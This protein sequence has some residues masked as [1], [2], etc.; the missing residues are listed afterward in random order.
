MIL[1]E[2]TP[3]FFSSTPHCSEGGE[4][5]AA[6]LTFAARCH[7]HCACC[8]YKEAAA[9]R[10]VRDHSAFFLA[11]LVHANDW[12][13]G[14]LLPVALH[15]AALPVCRLSASFKV[16]KLVSNSKCKK[17]SLRLSS[18]LRNLRQS[19]VHVCCRAGEEKSWLSTYLRV[20][21]GLK[22]GRREGR[23]LLCLPD[24]GATTT[25]SL[26]IQICSPRSV[27]LWGSRWFRAR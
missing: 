15:L 12:G 14:L 1:I 2:Q 13:F 24:R 27:C 19:I 18:V 10:V 7:L 3:A 11:S 17:L 26:V 9:I 23:I 4:E 22:R 21:Q 6:D 8:T 5:L 16:Q 20:E 25:I